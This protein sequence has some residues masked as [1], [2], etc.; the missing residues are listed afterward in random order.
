VPGSPVICQAAYDEPDLVCGEVDYAETHR[1]RPLFPVLRDVR[2]EMYR[3][4]LEATDGQI[5]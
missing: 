1:F 4:L 5:D 3:Q 2:A